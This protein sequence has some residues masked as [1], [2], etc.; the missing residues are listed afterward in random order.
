MEKLEVD[1]NQK[2]GRKMKKQKS[3]YRLIIFFLVVLCVFSGRAYAGNL[4]PSD[5]PDSTMKTL[6]QVQPRCPVQSLSG[7]PT[8][9]YLI[10]QAGSYY[11]THNITGEENKNGIAVQADNVTIDLNGFSIVGVANS[12]SGIFFASDSVG[13][14]VKNGLI[15]SWGQN[16]IHAENLTSGSFSRLTCE[17][18]SASG[19]V[20]DSDSL[21]SHCLVREN[22]SNGIGG[23]DNCIIRD[24]VARNN[25]AAGFSLYS[26]GLITDCTA[27]GNWFEGIKANY[28]SRITN[29]NVSHNR[30][31][32]V[33]RLGCYISGNNSIQNSEVGI[34]CGGGG[35][36]NRV[37]NNNIM[38]DSIGIEVESSNTHNIIIRNTVQNTTTPFAISSDNSYGPI[39]SVVGSGD[40]AGVTNADHPWANFLY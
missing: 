32:I 11:L 35:G 15:S 16:G 37:D 25:H 27:E 40:F 34:R 1:C 8:S 33:S 24:C 26:G 7:D 9:T 39:V 13:G 23:S 5:P 14:T 12:L 2:G 10:S 28:E 3:V 36:Q 31:G 20:M 4:D 22:G 38:S 29:C 21:V 6:A 17:A 30:W 19:I 18:N